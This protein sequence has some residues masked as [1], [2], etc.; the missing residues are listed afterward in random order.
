MRGGRL[1]PGCATALARS[2]VVGT[3]T[4][5]GVTFDNLTIP[6][7]ELTELWTVGASEW[8]AGRMAPSR[9]CR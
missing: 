2:A 4:A 3:G 6:P 9:R 7:V 1:A 8:R 5:P